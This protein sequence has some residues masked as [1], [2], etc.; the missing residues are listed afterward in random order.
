MDKSR[1]WTQRVKILDHYRALLERQ[2]VKGA[3]N[4][5]RWAKRLP[6][7]PGNPQRPAMWIVDDGQERSEKEDDTPD[8]RSFK[9]KWKI[10]LDL[11]AN[12]ENEEV[13][14]DWTERV[15]AIILTVLPNGADP[16]WAIERTNYVSDDPVDVVLSSG[17]SEQIWI[18]E[19]ETYY[20]QDISA[21]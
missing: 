9:L 11:A 2:Y 21:G 19:F 16:P 17:A 18:I 10:V 6:W 14:E 13:V 5:F 7:R 4:W 3:R 8:A 15:Q 20:L 12:W 1:Q